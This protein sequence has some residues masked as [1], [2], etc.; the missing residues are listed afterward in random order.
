MLADRG[1]E[2][3]QRPQDSGE[4]AQR[5]EHKQ[6]VQEAQEVRVRQRHTENEVSEVDIPNVGRITVR[7]DADGYN[8][9]VNSGSPDA[10]F[11][12]FILLCSGSSL[13]CLQ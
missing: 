7:A 5:E 4:A 12:S 13:L 1:R 8:E 9:E 10:C 11:C 3:D 6:E 2:A